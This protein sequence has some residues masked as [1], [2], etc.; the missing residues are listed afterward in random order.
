MIY[1]VAYFSSFLDAF[2]CSHANLHTINF[3]ITIIKKNMLMIKDIIIIITIFV[4]HQ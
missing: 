3:I 1:A 4:Y 2:S